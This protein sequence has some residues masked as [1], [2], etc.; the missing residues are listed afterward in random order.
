MNR[1]NIKED[2]LHYV[3][4]MKRFDLKDL[5]T[6]D[7]RSIEIL[8][9]GTHNHDAG[10]DF[11]EGKIR[12]DGTLWAGQ[13]EM[14]VLASDWYAHKHQQDPRY[15]GVILHVVYIADKDV[16]LGDGSTVPCLCIG[17]RIPSHIQD[18]Y[19]SLLSSASW[20]P[21]AELLPT[22]D[23]FKFSMWLQRLTSERL[24]SKAAHIL[25]LLE[26]QKGD[27]ESTFFIL[28][29]RSLGLK[30]NVDAFEELARA[31]PLHLLHKNRHNPTAI[32]ALL[33]GQSGLL[34][35]E[36]ADAYPQELRQLYNHLKHKYQLQAISPMHWK[37]SRMRPA[38]FPT[39]RIAQLAALLTSST[40]LFQY[41][42]D[43]NEIQDVLDLL[44]VTAHEYWDDH[45]RFGPQSEK[46]KPKKLGKNSKDLIL[47]NTV[48]PTLFA[49][50]QYIG[51]YSYCER[52]IQVL[53]EVSAEVNKIT[54]GY[55]SLGTKAS[56]AADSQALIHLKKSYCSAQR[57]LSCAIGH[58]VIGA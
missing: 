35:E 11:S 58:E 8:D 5:R 27:W 55:Q 16:T 31:V 50:G 36:T 54:K 53:Q 39:L 42:R 17:P 40:S 22:V 47:I 49:Y 19:Q 48:A 57:C 25:A 21:C 52:A 9:F 6:T 4:R 32:A 24:Q 15:D 2:L 34:P 14:H 20:I 56:S 28:L 38:A 30:V 46:S 23:P 7:G 26:D 45:Y 51:D 1:P 12:I 41:I 18:H 3:W 13:I 43:L 37:F 44:D 29:C 10:P 33:F